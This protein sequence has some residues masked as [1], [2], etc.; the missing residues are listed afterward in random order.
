MNQ[1]SP[2]GVA[3]CQFLHAIGSSGTL[4]A[5]AGSNLVMGQVGSANGHGAAAQTLRSNGHSVTLAPTACIVLPTSGSL[6]VGS[7]LAAPSHTQPG[8]LPSYTPAATVTQ[9]SPT[10]YPGKTVTLSGDGLHPPRDE[11]GDPGA[12]VRCPMARRA[13]RMP[14]G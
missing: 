14:S 2:S 13:T 9:P 10:V 5:W 3:L 6:H 8:P 4:T 11:R 7:A 12:W 1:L